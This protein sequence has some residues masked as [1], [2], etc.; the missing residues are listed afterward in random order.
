MQNRSCFSVKRHSVLAVLIIC[1]TGIFVALGSAQ[2]KITRRAGESQAAYQ[3]RVRAATAAAA[4]TRSG[5]AQVQF[6]DKQSGETGASYQARLRRTVR[7]L[8]FLQAPPFVVTRRSGESTA[9]YE[10]RC[11][12]AKAA[13]GRSQYHL[14]ARP[15]ENE[16]AYRARLA[17][18]KEIKSSV[19]IKRRTGESEAAYQARLRAAMKKKLTEMGSQS[20]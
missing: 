8:L 15:D 7:G 4:R 12:A 9:A 6:I 3:A 18:W 13:E 17:K 10:A 5:V 2:G 19:T 16:T 1:V 20:E 14:I 11:R